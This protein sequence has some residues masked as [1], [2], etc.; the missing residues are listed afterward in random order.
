MTKWQQAL[1]AAVSGEVLPHL[2]PPH[3]DYLSLP[4][5][6][7]WQDNVITVQWQATEAVYQGAGMVFG[8]YLSALA[9]YAAGIAMLTSLGDDEFFATHKLDI[10]YIKPVTAGLVHI[11]AVVE[12]LNDK[13]F[14]VRVSFTDDKGQ[15]CA[16]SNIRQTIIKE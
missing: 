12:K 15:L 2:V 7:S 11:K 6:T 14:D 9:D 10:E 13:H 4:P 8:G 5:I 3:V 16:L 1:N